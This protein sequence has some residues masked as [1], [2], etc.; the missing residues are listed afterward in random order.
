MVVRPGTFQKLR[1]FIVATST[2][3][4]NQF[5]M[6]KKLRTKATLDLM[7]E[8]VVDSEMHA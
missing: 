2:A 1:D 3:S 7:M 6:P 8:S 4:F 5:K